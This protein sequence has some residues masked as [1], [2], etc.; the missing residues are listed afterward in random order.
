MSMDRPSARNKW[1]TILITLLIIVPF[2]MSAYLKLSQAPI[3]IDGFHKMGVPDAAVIPIGIVE[4]VCLALYLAP[5]TVVLGT[6]MLTGYLGGAVFANIVGGTDFL[7]ALAIGLLVWIGALLRVPELRS[8]L[9]LRK[10][11]S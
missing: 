7:H 6:F 1:A 4:L 8:L 9:P 3:A 10:A 11:R 5:P 2:V